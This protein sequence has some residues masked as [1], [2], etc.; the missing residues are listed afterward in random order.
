MVRTRNCLKYIA[1]SK[2]VCNFWYHPPACKLQIICM[3]AGCHLPCIRSLPDWIPWI[4]N[5]WL[6]HHFFHSCMLE[7]RQCQIRH[8][9]AVPWS[10][11]KGQCFWPNI[12]NIAYTSAGVS[13]KLP[14]GKRVGTGTQF[15]ARTIPDIAPMPATISILNR[16]KMYYTIV[17]PIIILPSPLLQW[18][19]N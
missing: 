6:N 15:Y 14:V 12:N 5:E 11:I 4:Q 8:N 18:S 17:P 2:I 10:N 7:M 16:R 3:P 19:F 9:T 13:N 1:G